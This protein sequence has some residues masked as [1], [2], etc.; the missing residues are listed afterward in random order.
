M[1]W[2]KR[3]AAPKWWPIERKTRKFVAVPRGPHKKES[4][5]PLI[6]FIRDV[7]KLAENSNEAESVIK[8]GE[9]LVDGEK[10]KD[11]HYGIGLL[12]VIDIPSVKKSFR[13]IPKIGGGLTFIEISDSN[14]KICKIT[15]KKI[16]KGNKLQ[17]NLLGGRNF[18]SN[19]KYSTHD[20]L[21]IELPNQNVLE[22]LEF[23]KGN[24]ALVF[25]GKNA[26]TIG[27]IKNIEEKKI[28]I[29]EE[30]SIEVPRD[31]VIIV[32][33]DKSLIQLK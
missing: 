30:T 23:K 7:L 4:S 12:D 28:W 25:N 31:Y 6:V 5:L 21:L 17:F 22:H 15:N 2:M 18:I 13:A 10:R 32:G 16:L 14:K 11:P 1:A 24:L 20:S 27:K 9:I 26:G 29:G 8:K 3:L 19:T 33:K